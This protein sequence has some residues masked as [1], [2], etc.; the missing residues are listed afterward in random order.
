[1]DYRVALESVWSESNIRKS[2]EGIEGESN[3]IQCPIYWSFLKSNCSESPLDRT[4][5]SLNTVEYACNLSKLGTNC[6]DLLHA[7]WLNENFHPRNRLLLRWFSAVRRSRLLDI[8]QRSS[9]SRFALLRFSASRPVSLSTVRPKQL[10]RNVRGHQ[11]PPS[12]FYQCHSPSLHCCFWPRSFPVPRNLPLS[13]LLLFIPIP[14][15]VY[16]TPYSHFITDP[17][18]FLAGSE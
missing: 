18:V 10:L 7:E 17:I 13:H 3:K 8:Y 1:M 2:K 16:E 9:I 5:M 14:V 11:N 15:R 4:V 12:L 6:K